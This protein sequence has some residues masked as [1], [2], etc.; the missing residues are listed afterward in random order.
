MRI[1]QRLALIVLLAGIAGGRP[2]AARAGQETAD[3]AAAAANFSAA[4]NPEQKAKATFPFE[5]DEREDWHFIPKARKGLPVKEMNSAERALAYGLLSS[6]LS[7]KGFVKAMTIMSLDQILKDMENGS[8]PTRDP[9]LYYFS[10][11]GTPGAG[12][13]GW[14]VEGHHLS[15]NFTIGAGGEVSATPSFL[16]S[17]PDLVKQGLRKGLRILAEEDEVARALVKSLDEGQRAKAIIA[18]KAPS[19]IITMASRKVSPLEWNGILQPDL[20]PEQQERLAT[21]VKIYIGRER[22]ELAAKDWAKIA[23]AG[24]GKIRFAWAGGV[25]P[26]EKH[27]YRVQGPTFLLEYDNTQNDAN[28][29]HAVWRDFDHD[30]GVDLLA[31][32]YQEDHNAK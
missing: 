25:E 5:S 2:H 18:V 16:G 32:H 17:N 24:I 4:L 22:P 12:T 31:Q 30:F 28:H 3:M 14:R 23:K 26:G 27:Y 8:G 10:I 29:V 19:D 1:S 11:F 6:G 13:W 7:Q 15:V 9:E 20:N 21:L